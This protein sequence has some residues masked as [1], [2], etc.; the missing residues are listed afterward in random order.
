VFGGDLVEL[1]PFNSAWRVEKRH[2]KVIKHNR[3]L[4]VEYI[5]VSL[6]KI[7]A[8]RKQSRSENIIT[9]ISQ[10]AKRDK[11]ELLLGRDLNFISSIKGLI[12][13]EKIFSN[14]SDKGKQQS[15]PN[16]ITSREPRPAGVKD[17]L[18]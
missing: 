6:A 8:Y 9:Y 4:P 2:A 12:T 14:N 1:V 3:T 7:V 17:N 10:V 13:S 5:I 11:F 18:K 16:W 15:R